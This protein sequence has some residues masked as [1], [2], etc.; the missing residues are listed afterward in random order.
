MG[1][2][3]HHDDM[4]TG[5]F[6]PP[7]AL[8]LVL[9]PFFLLVGFFSAGAGHGSYFFAKVLFPFTMMSTVFYDEI[10][11]TF[12]VLGVFQFP[13]Y[14]VFLGAMNRLCLKRSAIVALSILH[15]CATAACFLLIGE[16]FS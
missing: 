9:T 11:L 4:E 10:T 16:N 14:G 7:F 3:K 5:R 6:I 2:A 15:V 12:L 13:I 1:W 8:I